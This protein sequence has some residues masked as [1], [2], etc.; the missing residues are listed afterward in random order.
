MAAGLALSTVSAVR[1]R[2]P[3]LSE[4]Q[5]EAQ[6]LTVS[7]VRTGEFDASRA[8][9]ASL[10]DD[11]VWLPPP[12]LTVAAALLVVRVEA[13]PGP[14]GLDERVWDTFLAE[15]RPQGR[16]EWRNANYALQAA[17]CL[18]GGL[19][20]DVARQ[21]SFWRLPLWPFALDVVELLTKI[22]TQQFE[23]SPPDLAA[24]VSASLQPLP[25]Q[26]A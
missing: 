1:V 20:L 26:P 16:S 8:R 22:A 14:L 2:V 4:R 24:A 19:W 10:A 18:A 25:L 3:E 17:G 9:L 23:I 11:R 7:A 13:Q 15:S 5:L 21:E 6:R 12:L